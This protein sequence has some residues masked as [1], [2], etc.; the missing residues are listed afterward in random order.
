MP[1][2]ILVG[3]SG[4]GKT[5]FCQAFHGLPL[6]YRK[7]QSVEIFNAV[8]DTPGEY[9]ENRRYNNALRVSSVGAGVD[10]V[11]LM[12]D[13]TDG[14]SLFPPGFAALFM[15]KPVVGIVSKTD[16]G[17]AAAREG[18]MRILLD[19]GCG[20]VVAASSVTGE[21]MEEFMDW[22]KTL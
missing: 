20:A 1:G 12:Q 5:S 10:A 7:T 18:A 11:V 4:C 13:C 16:L 15:G 21:G 3:R 17:T 9:L 6:S 14:E 2:F 19:A 8:V 22:L